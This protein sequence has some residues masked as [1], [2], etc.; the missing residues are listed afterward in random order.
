ML[1]FLLP[2]ILPHVCLH[3]SSSVIP[4]PRTQGEALVLVQGEGILLLSRNK[5]WGLSSSGYLDGG[6]SAAVPPGGFQ[7]HHRELFLSKVAPISLPS[8]QLLAG[9][10]ELCCAGGHIVTAR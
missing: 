7:G 8:P 3:L 9:T 10:A 4:Q 6:R 2:S 5:F 1:C